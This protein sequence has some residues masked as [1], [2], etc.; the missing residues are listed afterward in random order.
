LWKRKRQK[1][2]RV[3]NDIKGSVI[4]EFPNIPLGVGHVGV[5]HAI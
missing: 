4:I 5:G 2:I 3:K 1:I